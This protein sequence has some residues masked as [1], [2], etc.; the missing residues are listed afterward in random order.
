M[1]EQAASPG[2]GTS[3]VRELWASVL[4]LTA[5]GGCATSSVPP[6]EALDREIDLERFMGD[7]YVMGFIPIELPFFSEARAHNAVESYRHAGDG[8]IDTT[9]T[10]RDGAF[11]ASE[12]RVTSTAFVHDERTRTEWRMQFV[13]PIRAAYLIAALDDDYQTAIIGVPNRGNVWLLAR[14]WQI[15]DE[16]YQAMLDAAEALG[17][18]PALIQ[19]VPQSW[20][21]Q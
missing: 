2:R 3:L 10:F 7:W 13:W 5:L 16:A 8:V 12:R 1:P 15:D 18:D 11:D 19:R 4:S 21:T 6:L 9:Y 14:D 20:P 17:Y